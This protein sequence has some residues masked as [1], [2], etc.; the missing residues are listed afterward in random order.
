M[1]R[2]II[3]SLKAK[4][5]IITAFD[6]YE[7][8]Q[9]GLGKQFSSTVASSARKLG[10]GI[11]LHKIFFRDIRYVKLKR[12]SYTIFY[13]NNEREKHIFILGVLHN[14]QNMLTIINKRI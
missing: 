6:W 3:F 4:A 10:S 14:K 7:D 5:D 8:R 1:A 11:I 9:A 2:A 13:I 12:F